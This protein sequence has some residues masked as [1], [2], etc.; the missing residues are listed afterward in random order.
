[1]VELKNIRFG[2]MQWLLLAGV[3]M[4]MFAFGGGLAEVV[5]RWNRQEEYSHGYFIPL[6]TLWLLWQRRDALYASLGKPN[7]LGLGLV[8]AAAFMLMLGELSAIFIFIQ[9]GFVLCVAGLV[10]CFGGRPLL[11]VTA[12]PI[13]FLLFAIPLP[14]FVD[15]QLSWRLQLVSSKIGVEVLRL[16]GNTVYLEGNVIDLGVYKLQ[17]V[18]ACSGLRYLYPLMSIG[19]LMAYMFR[20]PLW[21]RGFVFLSSIPVT[22]LMN[23]LRIAVVGLLVDR[24]GSKMADGFLHYFEGW[25]IFIVC[26][27]VLAAEV[28]VF[29]RFGSRRP[30][31]DVL[32]VPAIAGAGGVGRPLRVAPLPLVACIVVLAMSVVAAQTLT[33]RSEIRPER[34][35]LTEFPL[36]MADWRASEGRMESQIEQFLGMD[37][38]VLADYR[39]SS[40]EVVNFYVAY[41]GSQRKGVSPHSPEVCIP[42][43]GWQITDL[44]RVPATLAGHQAFEVNRVVIDQ[45]GQRQIVYYW[46]EQRGRR[47]SN[48]YWMK[49]YLLSDSVTRNRTDGALV[50]LTT[51]VGVLESA[52]MADRRLLDFMQLAAPRLGP[53]VPQ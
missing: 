22:V 31:L 18:E 50:R 16:L 6:I 41:Y 14:Y 19:F 32:G 15:S 45:A 25:I 39:R 43:G 40:S 17:V 3:G 7:W 13:V 24:W 34:K 52:S 37:D 51:P 8:V 42:G 2:Q 5:S 36:T 38:Y 53:F 35:P 33:G 9:Y 12:L 48:E 23:S 49:W 29:E 11:R 1:M 20:A 10:V 26:L 4:A 47:I 27:A 30:L 28:W 44:S 21:Q 46:F